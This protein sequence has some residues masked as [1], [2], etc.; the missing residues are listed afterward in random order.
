MKRKLKKRVREYLWYT[1][2]ILT[3]VLALLVSS[4]IETAANGWEMLGWTMA[5]LLL[6]AAALVMGGFGWALAQPEQTGR[7]AHREA[8]NTVTGKRKAG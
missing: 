2:S 7:K 6:L 5:A 8:E 4:G 3:A 1:A